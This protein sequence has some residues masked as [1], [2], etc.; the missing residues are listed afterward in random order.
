MPRETLA[1]WG[2]VWLILTVAMVLI[3]LGLMSTSTHFLASGA[4]WDD[5]DRTMLDWFVAAR[6]DALVEVAK[7][8]HALTEDWFLSVLRWGT[9]AV[10]AFVKRWRHLGV[11]VVAVLGAETI[12]AGLTWRMARVR[13]DGID[14]LTD[15]AGFTF[16][17]LPYVAFIV[18]VVSMIFALVVP[19]RRRHRTLQVATVLIV[20][21]G[22]ARIYLGVDRVTDGIGAVIIGVALP[23]LAFRFAVPDAVYP[24]SYSLKKTAHLDLTG[25]RRE[26]ILNAS[27]DQLGLEAVNIELF[28]AEGSGGSTPLRVHLASGGH[29]FAKLYAQNHLRSD[30]WYKLGRS[31]LYGALEDEAPYRTVRQLAEHE[32]HMMRLMQEAGVPVAQP[33]GVLEI[34]A[35]R[36]YLIVTEFIDGAEELSKADIDEATVRAALHAVAAMWDAGLAHRDIKPANL[37]VADQTIYLIDHAFGE[38]RPTAWREAADL[39]NMIL[40]LSLRYPAAEVHRI[41]GEIFTAEDIGEAFAVARG[42][43]IPRE[44]R[45]AIKEGGRDVLAEN[46]G[47]APPRPPIGIQRWTPRRI[48]ALL[49]A[50]AG[51]VI[52]I[53][54]ILLNNEIAR[55]LL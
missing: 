42:V 43:T 37:L 40:T 25:R 51:G 48:W 26:A 9:I 19:G 39:A 32:D 2:K 21:V 31:L 41:A 23:V 52:L 49:S 12:A 11:F 33:Y 15:W 27:R 4:W 10:L 17:S 20:L 14:I 29:V 22:L 34:T 24:V 46:R 3:L 7:V 16:P 44:L 35:G 13:P 18:T 54:L 6:T 30:R 47:L 5:L 8:L 28:G 53:R 36:E 38:I 1:G 50:L 45:N 55:E